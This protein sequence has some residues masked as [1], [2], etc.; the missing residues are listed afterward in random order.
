MNTRF[1]NSSLFLAL[2]ALFG[3]GLMQVY[4]SSYIFA[5]ESYNDGLYFFKRQL[6]F[7]GIAGF[8]LL[9]STQ[10]PLGFMRKW[11]WVLWPIA[12]VLLC[13]T[14]IP[15]VGVRVG[16]ALRWI[17]LPLGFRF[18]PSELL[19]IAFSFLFATLVCRHENILGRMKWGWTFLFI[20]APLAV[21]LKQPDFGSFVIIMLVAATL[22]FTFGLSFKWLMMAGVAAIPVLYFAVWNVGY[23]RA[24]VQAFLDPWSDP[25][26]KGF[27]VIQSM[28]SVHSGGLTGAGLGQGQGKL[29]FLPE[30]HTD[31][32]MAVFFEEMG[33]IGVLAI[34]ALY[35]FVIFKGFQ[36]AVKAQ[37]MFKKTLALGLITTFAFSVF[38]NL[39]VVLGL[40][41]TKGLT[42]PF[43]S[44]GGSS[45]LVLSVLFG[46]LLNIEMSLGDERQRPATS[47]S[48]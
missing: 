46:I 4:S 39:G 20:V 13:A 23:R 35:G 27:Q 42:M 37:D 3:I 7:T 41:P 44:Y 47:R 12:F 6:I 14:F 24:R 34:L 2:V 32:T 11:S 43:M 21:L 40:V 5:T 25:A 19:K 26:S 31:F 38:I 22:L 48:F 15:G 16:G 1:F 36:I 9:V 8:A 45:L 33:F 17:Q 28:L 29:F 10:L 18:E 30:A